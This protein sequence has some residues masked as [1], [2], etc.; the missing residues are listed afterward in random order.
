MNPNLKQNIILPAWEIIQEHSKLK[1]FYFL[2]GL[3]SIIFL[4]VLLVY[5]AIYTYVEVFGY[6]EQ[7][8]EVILNF[9][10]S[11]YALEVIIGGAIFFII[12]ILISPIFE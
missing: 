1:R 8:F 4:S 6:K 12:Y 7:A 2:P 3:L 10:H 5:Q 11:N 9:F